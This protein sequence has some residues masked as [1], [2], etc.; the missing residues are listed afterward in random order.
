MRYPQPLSVGNDAQTKKQRVISQLLW[1]ACENVTSCHNESGSKP[2][3]IICA[4]YSF[5]PRY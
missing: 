3:G 5:F 4:K 2:R 1:I